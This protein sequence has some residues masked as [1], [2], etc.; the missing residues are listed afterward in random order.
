MGALVSMLG[1][2]VDS[3]LASLPVGLRKLS[4]CEQ[5]RLAVAF[6]VC[7][8]TA[9]LLGSV[10]PHQLPHP[11]ALLIYFLCALLL[12]RAARSNRTLL[13]ALPALLS[14]DNLFAGTPASLAFLLGLSSAVMA[15]LGLLL[16][17]ACRRLLR[18]SGGLALDEANWIPHSS[19][20][21]PTCSD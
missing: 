3:F 4:W 19:V 1:F 11:P 17:A 10:R 9:T 18:G 6:G 15:T 5:M 21:G 12:G 13:Y 14:I 8:A 2:G 16:A 7:D 20:A